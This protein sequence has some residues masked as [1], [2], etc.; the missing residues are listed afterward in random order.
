MSNVSHLFSLPKSGRALQSLSFVTL[1][2]HL[3]TISLSSDFTYWFSTFPKTKFKDKGLFF[4][5]V[6]ACSIILEFPFYKCY[7]QYWITVGGLFAVPL[8]LSD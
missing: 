7:L 3:F 8:D 6:F 4:Q 1:K 2:K 5:R